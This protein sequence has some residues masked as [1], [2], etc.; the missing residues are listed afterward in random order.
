M[1]GSY[2][3]TLLALLLLSW[4][5]AC[6]GG[7]IKDV[8][9][10]P[11]DSVY[12]LVPY[13]CFLCVFSSSCLPIYIILFVNFCRLLKDAQLL[14]QELVPVAAEAVLPELVTISCNSTQTTVQVCKLVP[15]QY[16]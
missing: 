9:F 11:N 2:P 13:I 5:T 14:D 8:L 15:P 16:W 6:Q 3:N 7:C 4:V 10:P 12:C 1:D